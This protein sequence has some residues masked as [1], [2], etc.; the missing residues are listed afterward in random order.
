LKRDLSL[1]GTAQEIY[2]RA[3]LIIEDMIYAIVKENITPVEQIGDPVVFE[4][5]KPEEGNL[6]GIKNIE[7]AYDLIRMLDADGYPH[8]FVEVGELIFRFTNADL[9]TNGLSANVQIV[10]RT[11]IDVEKSDQ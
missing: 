2:E 3:S 11:V 8:A 6:S 1:D 7:D 5:R 9:N 10:R 4:R